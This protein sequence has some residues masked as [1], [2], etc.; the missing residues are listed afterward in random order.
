MHQDDP[1]TSQAVAKGQINAVTQ[2]FCI[3]HG[4]VKK[5]FK[6]SLSP[7]IDYNFCEK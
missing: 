1:Q 6:M 7:V 3:S 4:P 2:M 5:I